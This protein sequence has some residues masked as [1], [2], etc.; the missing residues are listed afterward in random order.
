M[1]RA[2]KLT[3]DEKDAI[4][5]VYANPNISIPD[6]AK[7]F[8]MEPEYLQRLLKRKSGRELW[9]WLKDTGPPEHF[10]KYHLRQER[11]LFDIEELLSSIEEESND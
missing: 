4:I 7:R 10:K 3:E 8:E 6:V 9:K 11:Q 5:T 2:I 1:T